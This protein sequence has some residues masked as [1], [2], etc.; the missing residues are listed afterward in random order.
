MPPAL[1]KRP[2]PRERG[3]VGVGAGRT[4]EDGESGAT[5][6]EL[7]GAISCTKFLVTNPR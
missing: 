3:R 6:C 5:R 1:Q 7:S 2:L 4:G